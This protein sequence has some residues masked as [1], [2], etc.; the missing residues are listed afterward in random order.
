M[1]AGTF[2]TLPISLIIRST[3]SL[4]P[5]CS[6]PNSAATPAE[7]AENG[8]T[9]DEPTARTAFVEQFC[10]WSACRMKRI[11]SARANTGFAS[12]FDSLMRATIDRKF[13]T[14]ERRLSG[15]TNGSPF[16]WRYENAAIVGV[17]AS[18]RMIERL[19]SSGSWMFFALG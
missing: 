9:C 7:T 6:G 13:S 5:P 17:F 10:S 1:N 4:A 2:F 19:R 3:C 16:T 8:S 15:Y 11:S 14:Y 12:Y 18:R